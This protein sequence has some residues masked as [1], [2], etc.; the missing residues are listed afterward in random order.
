MYFSQ[1]QPYTELSKWIFQAIKPDSNTD[2]TF[3]EYVHMV[4]YFVMLGDKELSKFVFQ[5]ADT[6]DLQYLE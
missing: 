1:K 3:S 2:I 6:E 4:A 5:C